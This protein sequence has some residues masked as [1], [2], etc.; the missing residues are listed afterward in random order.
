MMNDRLRCNKTC[1]F[2]YKWWWIQHWWTHNVHACM[3]INHVG[4]HKRILLVRNPALLMR[5]LRSQSDTQLN[6]I[7]EW[8]SQINIVHIRLHW[9]GDEIWIFEIIVIISSW[10]WLHFLVMHIES[11]LVGTFLVKSS[12]TTA[13]PELRFFHLP[14]Q[15]C[16]NSFLTMRWNHKWWN[17]KWGLGW[18]ALSYIIR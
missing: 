5:G 8:W 12:A 2:F 16:D 6:W 7:F 10:S 13:V 14:M 17:H 15:L 3:C 11:K 4:G 1:G 9:T 18:K